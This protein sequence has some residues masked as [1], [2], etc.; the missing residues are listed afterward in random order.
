[1]KELLTVNANYYAIWADDDT[2][3]LPQVELCLVM[4]EP[5]YSVDAVG[6]LIRQ[7]ETSQCRFAAS[8]EHLIKLASTL[9]KLAEEAKS[10]PLVEKTTANEG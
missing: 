8:P 5:V 9:V 7:R 6:S 10:L 4:S 1:M 2:K 3:Q